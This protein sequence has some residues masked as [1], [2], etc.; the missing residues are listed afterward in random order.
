L[1]LS[2]KTKTRSPLREPLMPQAGESA[3]H[4]LWELVSDVLVLTLWGDGMGPFHFQ[5]Q[6]TPN[7]PNDRLPRS[8]GRRG[9]EG[10][11]K[12]AEN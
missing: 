9:V 2:E 5:R 4:A 6:A 7:D 3:T 11:P 1:A 8:A 12:V 10:T